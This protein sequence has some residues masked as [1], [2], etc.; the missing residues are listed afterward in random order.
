[1]KILDVGCGLRKRDGAVG[2]DINPRSHADVIHDLD[3]FP[4]P[5]A[6][7]EFDEIVCDNIL[8]HLQDI[9]RVMEELH[10]I[11][12]AGG[13]VIVIVPFFSHRN[14]FN[15]PTHRHFFGTRSFQY[16]IQ[17]SAFSDYKYSTSQYS[18]QSFRFDRDIPCGHWFERIISRFANTYPDVYE[19]RLAHIFPLR[20]LTFELKVV[21]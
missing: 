16:F 19:H 4:Y 9:I 14:A 8:E 18:L 20:T 6:D 5:F 7:N 10:R 21:K 2:I 3:Q 11:S 13:R 1:L 12:R 17:G 15:D